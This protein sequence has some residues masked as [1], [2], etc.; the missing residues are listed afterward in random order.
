MVNETLNLLK[1]VADETRLKILRAL[2]EKDSYVELLAER[3]NLSPATVSFH[4]KKLQN[5]AL[6]ES[7]QPAII[8][9]CLI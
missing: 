6:S 3:L 7:V 2:Y 4:M 1:T 8:A 9:Q 5:A